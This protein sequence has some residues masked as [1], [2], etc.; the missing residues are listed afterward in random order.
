MSWQKFEKKKVNIGSLTKLVI[1]FI[2]FST[3][4]SNIVCHS[5]EAP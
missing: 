1:C 5:Y 4:D 3:M 2:Y